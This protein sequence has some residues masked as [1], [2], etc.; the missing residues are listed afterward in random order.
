MIFGP[1]ILVA[2]FFSGGPFFSGRL[3]PDYVIIRKIS[4]SFAC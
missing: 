4:V 3:S 1:A 2:G